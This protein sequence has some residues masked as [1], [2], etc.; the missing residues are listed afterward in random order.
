VDNLLSFNLGRLRTLME[1]SARNLANMARQLRWLSDEERALT[2]GGSRIQRA[3]VAARVGSPEALDEIEALE[4][5]GPRIWAIGGLQART[6]YHM[7]RGESAAAQR[8]WAKAELEFVRLG[9]LWQLYAIH[10]SSAA[11]TYAYTD[12][13]LGLRRCIEALRRQVEGGLGFHAYLLLSR[14]E[15]ARLRGEHDEALGLVDEALAG[16][17]AG[18]GLPRAWALAARADALLAAGRHDEALAAGEAAR[19]H[20]RDPEY[21]QVGFRCRAERTL[22]LVEAAQGRPDAAVKRLDQL[23]KDAEV[24]DNPFILGA[25]HEAR[26]LVAA[27]LG[28]DGAAR[29]HATL[30]EACFVPT[31]NPVLVARYER[32]L[33]KI[34]AGPKPDDIGDAQAEAATAVFHPA[35]ITD[36]VGA[37]LSRLA[38]CPTASARAEQALRALL[39]GSDAD[40]GFLFL[41]VDGR[42]QLVAPSAGAEPPAGVSEAVARRLAASQADATDLGT[43]LQHPRSGWT[44]AMLHAEIDGEDRAVGA[45]VL[46]ATGAH[47]RMPGTSLC[48]ALGQRLYEEGDASLA[49]E[50]SG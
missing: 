15:H 44:T 23:I 22:A 38:A 3:L 12:D 42:P 31:R 13:M 6:Y 14:A 48:H 18:E 37:A 17:P 28:D 47:G 30:V 50:R 36:T 9:A 11:I 5:L 2:M 19:A 25:A 43:T 21:G 10:H 35:T 29:Y 46:H 49:S 39:E 1:S 27:E 20:A 34:G 24:I 45:V 40:E 8:V 4:Q 16:L 41:L 26:S 33:R 7:W 32:L